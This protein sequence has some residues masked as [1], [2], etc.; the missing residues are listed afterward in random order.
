MP[1][2]EA[3]GQRLHYEW[4][5]PEPADAPTLV[6]MHEGLGSVS[7]WRD[8]P[9]SLA[10]A[11]GC[12]MLNYSRRGYGQSE[13]IGE[14]REPHFMHDEAMT[15]LPEILTKLD[16]RRP[17]LVGHSDGGSIALIYAGS[18]AANGGGPTPEA[19][20]VEAAHV[21][22]EEL[23]TKSIT[24]IGMAFHD[25]E[26]PKKLGRHH[27]DPDGMFRAWHDIWLE[28]AFADWN[29]E[30]YLPQVVCPLLVIQGKNDEYGT[31]RQ[32]DAIVSQAGG[33][34]EVLMVDDCGHSPHRDQPSRV[35][36]AMTDFV[37]RVTGQKA[38]AA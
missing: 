17:I 18:G 38:S 11:T 19:M 5:G 2:V 9:E 27:D 28:P 24:Q 4:A 7:M 20:I 12:G 33:P 8:F 22:V 3:A 26:L 1:F 34:T 29:I 30:S 32:V 35:L 37:R 14:A 31:R 23:T 16:V 25:T 36:S 21:F 10:Q 6:F 13:P 15:V